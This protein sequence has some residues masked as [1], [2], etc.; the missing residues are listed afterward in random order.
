[1]RQSIDYLEAPQP[2]AR[3]T[4][5][6]LTDTIQGVK[7]VQAKIKEMD[8]QNLELPESIALTDFTAESLDILEHFGLNA[9]HLLNQYA[10][11][12]EDALIEQVRHLLLI[13][14]QNNQ[15]RLRVADLQ[16]QLLS[17]PELLCD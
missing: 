1:M 11:A 16:D 17:D 8:A 5:N 3:K 4:I 9:P 7:E 10:I 15:L 13:K 6:S 14:E 2:T 12:M